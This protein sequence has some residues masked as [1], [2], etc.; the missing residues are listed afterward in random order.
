MT[1]LFLALGL[2]AKPMIAT[3]PFVLLLLDY[4][5]LGRVKEWPVSPTAPMET[6]FRTESLA[7]LVRE[8]IPLLLLSVS[9]IAISL[10]GSQGAHRH[11]IGALADAPTSESALSSPAAQ[12]DPQVSNL[13]RSRLKLFQAHTPF[14]EAPAGNP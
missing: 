7:Q 12:Y 5:P 13:L 10:S 3:M 6:P 9:V 14:H 8:K 2:M 11:Q 4:W 1:A